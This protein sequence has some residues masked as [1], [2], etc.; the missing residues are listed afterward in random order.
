MMESFAVWRNFNVDLIVAPDEKLT[1]DPDVDMNVCTKFMSIHPIVLSR[2]M[3]MIL[4]T[5]VCLQ[6]LGNTTA[7][8]KKVV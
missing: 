3:T 8:V 7:Y 6:V 2:N 4:H 5:K 1:I